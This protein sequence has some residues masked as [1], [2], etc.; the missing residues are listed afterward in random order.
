VLESSF[1]K[2]RPPKNKAEIDSFDRNVICMTMEDICIW[3]KIALSVKKVL[4][5]I[6]QKGRLSTAKRR[7]YSSFT[8]HGLHLEMFCEGEEGAC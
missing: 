5:A 6:K 7:P 1:N 3:Q 4:V 8:S 2:R